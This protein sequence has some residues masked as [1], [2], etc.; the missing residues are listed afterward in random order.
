MTKLHRLLTRLQHHANRPWYAPLA[1]TSAM[2]D[3]FVFASP[4]LSLFITTVLLNP[5]RRLYAALCFSFGAALGAL[6]LALSV[7]LLDA[8]VE[9]FFPNH[10]DSAA[11]WQHVRTWIEAWG[12]LALLGVSII[13]LPLRSVV[14]LAAFT[15]LSCFAVGLGVLLGRLLA[16]TVL[17]QIV[18]Q[19]PHFLVRIPFVHRFIK[20]LRAGYTLHP[21]PTG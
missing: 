12:L 10:A 7:Q 3:Y 13:P 5:A 2:L 11:Y 19:A 15:G 14:V 20:A 8:P 1:A 4:A 9:A 17:G 6:L 18:Y 16:F 21:E